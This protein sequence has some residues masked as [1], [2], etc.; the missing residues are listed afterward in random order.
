M[1]FPFWNWFGFSYCTEMTG[2]F[3]QYRE[4]FFSIIQKTRKNVYCLLLLLLFCSAAIIT[5]WGEL[6][7]SWEDIQ[8]SYYNSVHAWIPSL[9]NIQI[10]QY[11]FVKGG[12]KITL[13]LNKLLFFLEKESILKWHWKLRKRSRMGTYPN[14]TNIKNEA[15]SSSGNL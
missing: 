7:L 15:N 5:S 8:Y 6:L 12:C 4:E 3:T 11:Y 1:Y 13:L 10:P 14:G 2:R 9:S